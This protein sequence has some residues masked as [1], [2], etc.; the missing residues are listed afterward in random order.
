MHG[1]VAASAAEVLWEAPA[2]AATSS[3]SRGPAVP[4]HCRYCI[5]GQSSRRPGEESLST[6]LPRITTVLQRIGASS[7]VPYR[8]DGDE[9]A[10]QRPRAGGARLRR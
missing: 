1:A 8:G 2:T 9:R 3:W 4:A 10:R 7:S 6:F 5:T